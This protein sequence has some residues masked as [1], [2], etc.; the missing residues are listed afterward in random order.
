ML[1]R[2]L[3]LYRLPRGWS[4]TAAELEQKLATR[5]LAACTGLQLQSRGW[6]A[7]AETAALVYSQEKHLLIALGVE[8]KLLPG[9]VVRQ[10]ADARAAEY[11]RLKGFKPGRKMMREVREQV[12]AE[13][14]PRAFVRQR[15]L[16][17]W[18]DLQTGWIAVDSSS[19]ARA[20]ELI[21]SLRDTLGELPVSLVETEHAPS[22]TLTAWLA[23][24]NPPGALALDDAA[25]IVGSDAS[26]PTVSYTR[27]PLEGEE[28]LK[29][30]I[31]DGKFATELAMTWNERIAFVLTEKLQVRR[32]KFLAVKEDD[33]QVAQNPEEQFDIDFALTVG[34]LRALVADLG[35]AMRFRGQ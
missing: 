21:E 18:I 8:Q 16:L 5:P 30:H 34:E 9:A 15:R 14:L 26:K 11:E 2:N 31:A 13:L 4:M 27:H 24:G 19:N 35:Q 1:F 33:D 28:G 25:K 20:E 12:T 32:V 3:I 23:S 7:P 10:A 6:V 22:A 17:A 29:R